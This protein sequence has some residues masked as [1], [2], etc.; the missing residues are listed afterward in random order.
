MTVRPTL[1]AL[2]VVVRGAEVLLVR[3][4]NKPDAGLWGYPG[5]HV[6]AGETV[7]Q[8]AIRELREETSIRAEA[9]PVLRGID[10]IRRGADG[11]LMH[12]FYLVAVLCHYDSGVPVAADDAQEAQWVSLDM[13]LDR[14]L[15]MSADVDRLLELACAALNPN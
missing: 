9:G 13:V 8:A 15:P 5:G 7:Q 2:A 12:H 11:A 3:R 10:L 6:E 4:R 1:G 14:A